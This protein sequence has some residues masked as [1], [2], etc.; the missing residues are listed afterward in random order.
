MNITA[1]YN[2][3]NKECGTTKRASRT[4]TNIPS[5]PIQGMFWVF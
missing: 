2:K 4:I 1:S 5:T 3:Y